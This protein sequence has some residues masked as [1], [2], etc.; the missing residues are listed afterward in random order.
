MFTESA[1]V[2]DEAVNRL[3]Y[4]EVGKIYVGERFRKDYGDLDDFVESIKEK[5][6]FTPITVRPYDHPDYDY[7][8]MAG[9][10]RVAGTQ[11]AGLE[12]IPALIRD[13]GDD[14]LDLR[15]VELF[16]NVFRKD[17]EWFEKIAL[18]NRVQELWNEKYKETPW[19]WSARKCA[20]LFGISHTH[21]NRQI[22]LAK[23]VELIPELKKAKDETEARKKLK[24]LQEKVVVH[25]AIEQQ[26][27]QI[28]KGGLSLVK[29]ADSN[30]NIG[31]ALEGMEALALSRIENNWVGA[32]LIEIDPPYAIDLQQVKGRKD[33]DDP[34]LIEY[35]EV[36][37]ADYT[38]FL[39]RIAELSYACASDNAWLVFWF[40]PSWFTDVKIA[41]ARAGW[42][43]D[44]IPGI[45]VKPNGQTNAP[46]YYLARCY[47]PFFIARKGGAVVKNKGRANVFAVPPVAPSAKYHPTQR[48]LALMEDILSTF[49]HPNS[50]VLSPFLG[51]GTTIRAAYRQHMSCF[52]W[53]L[54]EEYKKRFLLEIEQDEKQ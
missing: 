43:L 48:P 2:N 36:E 40:G 27:V 49:A 1:Q 46:N 24:Q 41:L 15:E 39:G 50:I 4:I 23:A 10:R 20:K 6:V 7:E 44:P 29:R 26:K 21:L 5:G 47:E 52:G 11:A 34:D 32:N 14:D 8:L 13:I 42:T 37:R 38:R 35:N 3:Q 33:D 9:G 53:D 28:A 51:S 16:E 18:V 19:K 17:M 31:D 12:S 25:K 45:W 54:S 30:Y 22:D